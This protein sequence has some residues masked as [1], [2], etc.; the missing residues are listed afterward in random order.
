MALLMAG[1][2]GGISGKVGNV[3]GGSWK[4]KD[5]IRIHKIPTMSQD[6][7]SV[8]ARAAMGFL[9]PFG[10]YNNETLLKDTFAHVTKGKSLS[11]FN[12][13]ISVN[14]KGRNPET[15]F[16][17]TRWSEG[18]VQPAPISNAVYST[19]DD[20]FD[21]DIDAT[22]NAY[23]SPDDIVSIFVSANDD[24]ACD[25]VVPFSQGLKRSQVVA[26]VGSGMYKILASMKKT[27]GR[28][29]VYLHCVCK[30]AAGEV[31]ETSTTSLTIIT[32]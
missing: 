13:F 28:S 17:T 20:S 12:R 18:V 25:I 9:I 5:W 8:A 24:P 15:A 7:G 4:G 11:P 22:V 3:V 2:L 31:S 21:F 32:E 27:G 30:N 1:I 23:G 6:A 19:V 29:G 26:L 16:A 14:N 10:K